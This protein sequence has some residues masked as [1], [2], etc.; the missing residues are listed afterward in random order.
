MELS[1]YALSRVKEF[2][3]GDNELTP[4]LR[5]QQIVHLFNK[6]GIKDIY[7]QGMPNGESRNSYA[8]TKLKEINGTRNLT[9]ILMLVF[10]SQRFANEYN[11]DILTAIQEINKIIQEDGYKIEKD[12]D[13]CSI[14]GADL[15][16]EVEVVIHFEDIQKQIIE[17]IQNAR[18]CIWIAVAW[19]TDKLI[20]REL[21]NKKQDGLNVRLVIIDDKINAEY[22]IKYEDF[23]DTLRVKPTGKFQNMMHHKFCV[24]DLKTVIHGSYNWTSR[25]KYNNETIS[26]DH[27]KKIAEKF[28][29]EFI[30]LIK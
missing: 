7:D 30:E 6:I 15:P 16:E 28:A 25:A 20:M 23:F 2:I 10:N 3:T 27:G 26:I 22:G 18:F 11:I 8:F 14:I 12:G 19:F 17:Q 24:I 4:Y 1:E 9:K 5:G 21:Y 13:T 29:L